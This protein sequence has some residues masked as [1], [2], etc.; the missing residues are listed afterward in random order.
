M[1]EAA[2]KTSDGIANALSVPRSRHTSKSAN[3]A[4]ASARVISRVRTRRATADANSAAPE[5]LTIGAG[6]SAARK[7]RARAV[8]ASWVNSATRTLASR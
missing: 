7:V 2:A 5:S 3:T 4:R 6:S 8:K 1:N